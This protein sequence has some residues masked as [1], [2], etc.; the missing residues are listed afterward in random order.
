MKPWGN[1]ALTEVTKDN[2]FDLHKVEGPRRCMPPPLPIEAIM[3]VSNEVRKAH[4]RQT[5]VFII[6]RLMTHLW[7]RQL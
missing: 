6:S 3:V 4:P 7:W 5:R 1:M 2:L